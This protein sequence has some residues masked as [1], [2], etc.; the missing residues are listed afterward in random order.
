MGC[1]S[2]FK[3]NKLFGFSKWKFCP[4]CGRRLEKEKTPQEIYD[5]YITAWGKGFCE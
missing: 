3:D 2:E 5:E 1:Y 4:I